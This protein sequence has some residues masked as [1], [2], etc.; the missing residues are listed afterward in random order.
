MQLLGLQPLDA[1][2]SCEFESES[3]GADDESANIDE[4]VAVDGFSCEVEVLVG[5]DIEGGHR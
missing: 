3:G 1:L 4:D 2:I 5:L